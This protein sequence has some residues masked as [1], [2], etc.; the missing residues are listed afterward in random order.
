MDD[1]SAYT[2]EEMIA[3]LEY[4]LKKLD[5]TEDDWKTIMNAPCQTEDDC[6]NNKKTRELNC[7]P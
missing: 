3:D 7:T 4:I 6:K 5:K 1:D 2:E